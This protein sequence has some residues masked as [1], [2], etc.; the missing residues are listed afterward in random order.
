[1]LLND[2][3]IITACVNLSAESGEIGCFEVRFNA[4]HP[5]YKGH[6]P[7]KP[8]TPGACLVQIAAELLAKAIKKDQVSPKTITNL[9]FMAPHTPEQPLTVKISSRDE[10]RF[11][12]EMSNGV[13]YFAKMTFVL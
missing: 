1:M 13:E 2:F 6:F 10:G 3:Y 5:I 9:K 11:T 7:S 4:E 8:I 12:V